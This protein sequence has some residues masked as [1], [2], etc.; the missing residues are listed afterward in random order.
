MRSYSPQ[1]AAHLAS[2]TTTLCHCWQI[3]RADGTVLG[4]TDHDNNLEFLGVTHEAS[5]GFTGSVAE[6]NLQLNVDN[7]D[8]EGFLDSANITDEDVAAGK[9]ASAEVLVFW[10]NHQ[11]VST[12]HLL[13]RSTI[14]QIRRSGIHFVFEVS[15]LAQQ[16]QQT[17]GSQYQRRCSVSLGSEKCGVDLNDSDFKGSGTVT[18]VVGQNITA[19]G[20]DAYADGW[21]TGGVVFFADGT[22]NRVKLHQKANSIVTLTL[23]Q[24][25]ASAP[26]GGDLFDVTA[27]CDKL[28]QTCNTKFA[29]RENFRG[30]PRIPGNDKIA[31]YPAQGDSGNDGLSLFR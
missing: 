4:F 25:T 20:L 19:S 18:S 2:K 8:I 27:G 21:F 28:I 15:G 17:V 9:Y 1:F 31:D 6:Q 12:F 22:V 30:Y 3:I 26:D 5:S 14:T 13:G 23:W 16:L 7:M 11:D 24:V 10:V 29:N